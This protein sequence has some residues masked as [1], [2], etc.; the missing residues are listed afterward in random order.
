VTLIPIENCRSALPGRDG[1]GERACSKCK[2]HL[3]C[4]ARLDR[5]R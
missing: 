1:A 5:Q 4:L 2:D 3:C